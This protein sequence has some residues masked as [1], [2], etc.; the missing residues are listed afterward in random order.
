MLCSAI[1]LPFVVMADTSVDDISL[2]KQVLESHRI[3]YQQQLNQAQELCADS[4]FNNLLDFPAM[5]PIQSALGSGQG[6]DCRNQE[7]L[8]Q[9][10]VDIDTRISKL[11]LAILILKKES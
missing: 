4:G 1:I 6:Q 7:K 9:M 5:Q 3:K 10:I 2:A 11:D 8:Q